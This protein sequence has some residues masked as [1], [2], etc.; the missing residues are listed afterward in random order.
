MVMDKDQQVEGSI[1]RNEYISYRDSFLGMQFSVQSRYPMS[2]AD[3]STC[4]IAQRRAPSVPYHTGMAYG[5]SQ[6]RSHAVGLD[7]MDSSDGAC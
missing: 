2:F 5:H 3:R 7:S 4:T 6:W 1:E